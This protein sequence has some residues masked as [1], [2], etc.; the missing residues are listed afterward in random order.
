MNVA[1]LKPEHCLSCTHSY[2]EATGELFC[3]RYP[4]E[5]T[6]LYATAK[7]PSGQPQPVIFGNVS[8]YPKVEPTWTCGEW[9]QGVIKATQIVDVANANMKINGGN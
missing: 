6:T 8:S 4:P 2:R 7:G 3:R 1:L 5:I 9:K